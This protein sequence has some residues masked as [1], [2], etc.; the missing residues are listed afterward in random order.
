MGFLDILKEVAQQ[1]AKAAL[2]EASQPATDAKPVKKPEPVHKQTV[3]TP[4]EIL[5]SGSI[6]AKP[7]LLRESYFYD[8]DAEYI[9]RFR[10]SG[11]FVEFDSHAEPEACHQYEPF[12]D[13]DFTS[14]DGCLPYLMFT[15]ENI[16][17]KAVAAFK[18]NSTVGT[19]CQAV[20]NGKMLFRAK[21]PYY[22]RIMVLYGFD[23]GSSWE[24]FGMCMVYRPDVEGTPL[25]QKLLAALDEAAATYTEERQS[26]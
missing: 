8:G 6:P 25:E 16:V 2:A 9:M 19:E 10:L 13:T 3:Q 22:D 7:S 20:T 26:M 24:N 17:D 5:E 12:S 4:K 15:N 11:D 21:L 1:A 14:Y 23:R 18:K